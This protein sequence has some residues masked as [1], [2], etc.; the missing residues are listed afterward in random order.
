MY[1]QLFS[2]H[3]ASR[4]ISFEVD[5]QPTTY[6]TNLPAGVDVN[7]FIGRNTDIYATLHLF[8]KRE[9]FIAITG[10]K[11]I[12]KTALCVRA[13]RYSSERKSHFDKVTYIECRD[14]EVMLRKWEST[15]SK[16]CSLARLC[17]HVDSQLMQD[18]MDMDSSLG[19]SADR[20]SFLGKEVRHRQSTT[21]SATPAPFSCTSFFD[22]LSSSSDRGGGR[23][24]TVL[25]G[26]D[27]LLDSKHRDITSQFMNELLKNPQMTI[28]ATSRVP[29]P[30]L[31]KAH[32]RPPLSGNDSSSS[33]LPPTQHL[34]DVTC[35]N[36]ALPPLDP[37]STALMLIKTM[38]R[39]LRLDEM[40]SSSIK[41]ENQD[42]MDYHRWIDMLSN[43]PAVLR[44]QGL[45]GEVRE[46]A[47]ELE[48]KFMDEC[49][50]APTAHRPMSERNMKELL[51]GEIE[52]LGI[53]DQRCIKLW[54]EC[55]FYTNRLNNTKLGGAT[56]SNIMANLQVS[57]VE[58]SEAGRKVPNDA[59]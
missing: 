2:N 50:E 46:L 52:K 31:L 28:L 1:W 35:C 8:S 25:D 16:P 37:Y 26:L 53:T 33:I 47:Q 10:D 49:D 27:K 29:L 30:T 9:R 45:P 12:G 48:G 15:N 3:P 57:V 39:K 44:T 22:A 20:E 5:P 36:Q 23:V 11:G 7:R 41:H 24:L 4:L 56:G 19:A 6:H 34:N 54:S 40:A 58:R 59:R 43:R 38:H 14:I 42:E 21:D 51:E 13:V 55:V 17:K 32:Q 18:M